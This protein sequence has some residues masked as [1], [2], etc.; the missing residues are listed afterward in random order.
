MLTE[1][2]RWEGTG[3]D[4]TEP[5]FDRAITSAV[6]WFV[7]SYGVGFFSGSRP[8]LSD[9]AIDGALMGASVVVSDGAHR[10]LDLAPCGA[11]SAVAT[12]AVFAGAQKMV[13]GSN[14]YIMNF[15]MATANDYL[16]DGLFYA[17]KG[18]FDRCDW[19]KETKTY[20]RYDKNSSGRLT[21]W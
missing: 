5:G 15:G 13:R 18:G 3:M 10:M 14:S 21:G 8:T 6:A 1:R 17:T 7:V 12:G 19:D 4:K 20:P 9:C 11:S 2:E 16:V